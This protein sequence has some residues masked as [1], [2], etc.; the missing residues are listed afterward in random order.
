MNFEHHGGNSSHAIWVKYFTMK[1]HIK[2]V[3]VHSQTPIDHFLSSFSYNPTPIKIV[4][5]TVDKSH[6]KEEL[7]RN[8]AELFKFDSMN[9]VNVFVFARLAKEQIAPFLHSPNIDLIPQYLLR[10]FIVFSY[11][12]NQL[13]GQYLRGEEM[14]NFQAE[15]WELI[16]YPLMYLLKDQN[17]YFD[18]TMKVIG[19]LLNTFGRVDAILKLEET[20]FLYLSFNSLVSS[21]LPCFPFELNHGSSQCF[22]F[23]IKAFDEYTNYLQNNSKNY[24]IIGL[25][26]CFAQMALPITELLTEAQSKL[27]ILFYNKVINKISIFTRENCSNAIGF[28]VNG[29]CFL[30][31]FVKFFDHDAVLE[32][33]KSI[34]LFLKWLINIYPYSSIFVV[35][36][37]FQ[38]RKVKENPEIKWNEWATYFQENLSLPEKFTKQICSK[39]LR[40]VVM[41]LNQFF[42]NSLTALKTILESL[43]SQIVEYEDDLKYLIS[44]II[45]LSLIKV[46]DLDESIITHEF[47]I[48]NLYYE[49]FP[50][51][52]LNEIPILALHFHEVF[53]H[54]LYY[55]SCQKR[56][57]LQLV[58]DVIYGNISK[59]GFPRLIHYLPLF[60]SLLLLDSKI[61]F[62]HSFLESGIIE[63]LQISLFATKDDLLVNEIAEFYQMMVIARPMEV[64]RSST[65]LPILRNLLIIERLQKML[66]PCFK[67]GMSLSHIQPVEIGKQSV[68][69]TLE[70]VYAI[71]QQASQDKSYHNLAIEMVSY[72]TE[73]VPTFNISI[74]DDLTGLF[75]ATSK[76]PSYISTS[77]AFL[78]CLKFF[79]TFCAY[80]PQ[81]L[82][83]VNSNSSI[84][85]RDFESTAPKIKITQDIIDCLILFMLNETELKD[86]R[87]KNRAA[88]RLLLQ[89]SKETEFEEFVLKF[90]LSIC[91]QSM[92][93]NFECF[94]CDVIGYSLN[95]IHKLTD[96]SLNLFRVIGSK[97]F[98]PLA[99]NQTI[100]TMRLIDGKREI[101]HQKLID[102]FLSMMLDDRPRPVT[103]FFHFANNGNGIIVTNLDPTLFN[104]PF[105]FMTTFR[106][107]SFFDLFY[108]IIS[109]SESMSSLVAIY[110]KNDMIVVQF[111]QHP[112]MIVRYSFVE[113]HWYKIIA[114]FNP[115]CIQIVINDQEFDPLPINKHDFR[116]KVTVT[117]GIKGQTSFIG[118]FGPS[119]FIRSTNVSAIDDAYQKINL[120]RVN[121]KSTFIKFLPWLVKDEQ[122]N[123]VCIENDSY[124]FVG[125]A[126]PFCMTITQMIRFEGTLPKF[127]PLFILLNYPISSEFLQMNS[128]LNN[129]F[130][131]SNNESNNVDKEVKSEQEMDA[132]FF[133]SVLSI[134]HHILCL[135]EKIQASFEKIGGFQ[136]LAGFIY[137]VKSQNF[138]TTV[139]NDLSSIYQIISLPSLRSQ[140]T[141]HIWLNFDLWSSMNFELQEKLYSETLYT[142]WSVDKSS[143]TKSFEF[144]SIDF[145]LYQI[146]TPFDE[147]YNKEH[148]L[149]LFE[150]DVKISNNPVTLTKDEMM[151]IKSLQWKFIGDYL[152][153]HPSASTFL[154]ILMI[155]SFH[156]DDNTRIFALELIKNSIEKRVNDFIVAIDMMDGYECLLNIFFNAT[157]FR[158]MY[159]SL[160]CIF[161]LGI[162]EKENLFSQSS[163]KFRDVLIRIATHQNFSNVTLQYSKEEHFNILDLCF[164]F[165]FHDDVNYNRDELFHK[166][167]PVKHPE[168]LIVLFYYS[169]FMEK[170][171]LRKYASKFEL[172]FS[173]FPNEL[174]EMFVCNSWEYWSFLFAFN[175]YDII[176]E[177]PTLA[178]FFSILLIPAL[179]NAKT[180]LI[181]SFL[182]FLDVLTLYTNID[183][184]IIK[185]TLLRILAMTAVR[186]KMSNDILEKLASIIFRILFIYFDIDNNIFDEISQLT[187]T[188]LISFGR[189]LQNSPEDLQDCIFKLCFRYTKE[190]N[191]LTVEMMSILLELIKIRHDYLLNIAGIS[192]KA[193]DLFLYLS[194]N[195][196]ETGEELYILKAQ[197]ILALVSNIV[198]LDVLSDNGKIKKDDFESYIK[199]PNAFYEFYKPR[200]VKEIIRLS[201][202]L[203]HVISDIEKEK[204]A[205]S[206][207][208]YRESFVGFNEGHYKTRLLSIL[209]NQKLA[210]SFVRDVSSNSGPWTLNS[211][212]YIKHW[213]ALT[214]VDDFGHNIYRAINRNFD[215]HKKASALR[216]SMKITEEPKQNIMQNFQRILVQNTPFVPLPTEKISTISFKAT[217]FS[218]KY[219][220]VGVLYVTDRRILFDGSSFTE[221][222]GNPDKIIDRSNKYIEIPI[223]RIS[224]IFQRRHQHV[225]IGIEIF[226]ISNKSYLFIMESKNKRTE[227][228]HILKKNTSEKSNDKTKSKQTD[229]FAPLRAACGCCVQ[230]LSP[231]ELVTKSKITKMWQKRELSN[232]LYLFY[233]NM[234]SGR[235]FN[236][237]SQYPVYPWVLSDY[238]SETID[239]NNSS[240]YRDFSKPIGSYNES[241]L[242]L[243]MKNMKMEDPYQ[244]CLYRTHF[245]SPSVVAGFLIRTEPFASLHIRLQE[246]RFDLPGRLF[247]S[248]KNAWASV[249]GPSNDFREL[250][251]EFFC[252]EHFLIN[253]NGFDF[254]KHLNNPVNDAELPNWASSAREFI[255]I[256]R[257]ALESDY[258]SA[259]LE[260]WIDLIF[261][262]YQISTEKANIYH[263][264]SYTDILPPEILNDPDM[265]YVAQNHAVNFGV[266]PIKL[267]KENHPKR[268][269]LLS[270]NGRS[271]STHNLNN[272]PMNQNSSNNFNNSNSLFKISNSSESSI[273][274]PQ[275]DSQVIYC[276]N[277]C[278]LTKKAKLI[279]ILHN[280]TQQLNVNVK[281]N[282]LIDF[283]DDYLF[284]VSRGGTCVSAIALKNS[285]EVGIIP[286]NNL[287]V[288]CLSCVR[289]KA[290]LVGGSDCTIDIW[291]GDNLAFQ[292]TISLHTMPIVAVVGCDHLDL[293]VSVDEGHNVFISSLKE[294]KFINTFQVKTNPNSIHILRLFLS[295]IIALSASVPGESSSKVF[296][297]NLSGDILKTIEVPAGIESLETISTKTMQEFVIIATSMKTIFIYECSRFQLVKKVS[298]AIIPRF[299][300][301]LSQER[302]VVVVRMKQHQHTLMAIDI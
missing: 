297:F 267:F 14:T 139:I 270:N 253:E 207:K 159:L 242:K 194:H 127:L 269:Q 63:N 209:H 199:K 54:F 58:L 241:R 201:Y 286:H 46:N 12:V 111:N 29:L 180:D 74:F 229:L 298:E 103:S 40:N 183:F 22:D 26:D 39:N 188:S 256:H 154:A 166:T 191:E 72:M 50:I 193:L 187:N 125:D 295:G 17:Q 45:F 226:T 59:N 113:C 161:L 272:I 85:I 27:I 282:L 232:F 11:R 2:D 120:S 98:S 43:F 276:R 262:I 15:Y 138:S 149:L 21:I 173:Q 100:K 95:R 228:L 299:M 243:L 250:I 255:Q 56:S 233:L 132:C 190:N 35:V 260:N 55:F 238:T 217:Q 264:F 18:D 189:I 296:F 73:S 109:I 179:T 121:I 89:I 140:M 3:D 93:N 115:A 195:V 146:Q 67:V 108:P 101:I 8:L 136:L 192:V 220:I 252:S 61:N 24:E 84:V 151:K 181:E 291:R 271:P 7:E 239:L 170:V 223:N 225:D 77:E 246:G 218:L 222:F 106:V 86:Q 273:N 105:S 163:K 16:H 124:R 48:S 197:N 107:D 53:L 213:K 10:G 210:S 94:S 274:L 37:E 65:F 224:F 69:E 202:S 78:K 79:N 145:L 245:S 169:Q 171:D 155:I 182:M 289:N 66:A 287:A 208:Q 147:L 28:A 247:F 237:I 157:N 13:I 148:N 99:L 31:S 254:G 174:M 258:V 268:D 135:S 249:T 91:E 203:N 301:A 30:S 285:Q 293:I 137:N 164:S 248:I 92:F 206:R 38:I 168:A 158:T 288:T 150:T 6:S 281:E 143:G 97:F 275:I 185:L 80:F 153:I 302:I 167:E 240:V 116:D 184:L 47:L 244:R 165:V 284:E 227:F 263:L 96:L 177:A 236:D 259:H 83:I 64:F 280:V 265:F 292:G 204:I 114:I 112:G 81:F 117:F 1:C 70:Q 52:L 214:K 152:E 283:N 230:T 231:S 205:L 144:P 62:V 294:R 42:N 88:L 119:I 130:N 215:D 4:K 36:G 221:T 82:R 300:T 251:P 123:D 200:L 162:L 68:H 87:I 178:Y 176:N 133:H 5:K 196:K 20:D 235:S 90:I 131:H 49:A 51:D 156:K 186:E 104:E 102:T 118:D 172:I 134:F 57:N 75:E 160:Q 261:G 60:R 41:S 71:L 198:P 234:I 110:I 141:E 290:I 33:S 126:I 175:A 34:L 279:N 219:H 128:K 257:M 44:I 277:G 211:D 122:I 278:I 19:P 212:N 25:F 23:L 129:E 266:C 9:I 76:L 216:D 142:I 32:I